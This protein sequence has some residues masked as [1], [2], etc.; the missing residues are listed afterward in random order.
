MP[1]RRRPSVT[2]NEPSG[3][4]PLYC[5]RA[6][7]GQS[8][9]KIGKGLNLRILGNLKPQVCSAPNRWPNYDPS[10]PRIISTFVVPY[11]SFKGTGNDSYPVQDF[12]F[13]Y[14]TGWTGNAGFDNP[15]QGKGDDPVPGNDDGVIVGHFIKYIRTVN[16]GGGGETPCDLSGSSI[17]GCVAVMTR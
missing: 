11:G 5:V 17:S 4:Q 9:S 15:C 1:I 8:A 12:A 10:D 2:G 13:F 14:I 3:P 16:D 7:T 6:D